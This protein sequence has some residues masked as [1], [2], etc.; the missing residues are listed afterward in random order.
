MES[1]T[2]KAAVFWFV[3]FPPEPGRRHGVNSILI[4]LTWLHALCSGNDGEKSPSLL[5]SQLEREGFLTP[6]TNP[7]FVGMAMCR[8]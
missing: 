1:K 6:I 8:I 5:S 2:K 4:L 3:F 7:W